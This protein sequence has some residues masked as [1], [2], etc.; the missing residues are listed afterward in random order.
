[1]T[2]HTFDQS[3]SLDLEIT[4]LRS[5]MEKAYC[6]E[7]RVSEEVLHWSYQLDTKIMEYYQDIK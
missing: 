5:E 7:G 3:N 2:R 1:M 4:Q 6:R